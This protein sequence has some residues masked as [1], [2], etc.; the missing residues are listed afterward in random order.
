MDYSSINIAK[1]FHIGHL[2]TTA[3]GNSLNRIYKFL[4]YKVVG[5]NHLGDWG[6]QFGKLIVAYKL[7]GNDEQIERDSIHALLDLYVRFHEEAEK[8]DSLNEEGRRWF[9]KI[10]DGDQE[11]L[12]IFNWFKELTLKE[13]RKS[14]RQAWSQL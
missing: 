9:K 7:W 14:I 2:S 3:I 6:T 12:R 11:A 10:E 1:P 5:V 4:G 13:D 8:D